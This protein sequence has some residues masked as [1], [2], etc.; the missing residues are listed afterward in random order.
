MLAFCPIS[1]LTA[2]SLVWFSLLDLHVAGS[3]AGRKGPF[4]CL[5]PSAV[6]L[7]SSYLQ[8]TLR[9]SRTHLHCMDAYLEQMASSWSGCCPLTQQTGNVKDVKV[10]WS[11]SGTLSFAL[12]ESRTQGS[13]NSEITAFMK[14]GNAREDQ[15]L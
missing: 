12:W 8:G 14:V 15:V 9:S 10:G 11:V 13:G 1:C 5:S 7:S 6:F 3:N 4:P 2:S